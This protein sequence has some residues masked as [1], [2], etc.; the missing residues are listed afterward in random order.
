MHRDSR[1]IHRLLFVLESG[2]GQLPRF[3]SPWCSQAAATMLFVHPPLSFPHVLQG[4]NAPLDC[5]HVV[6][7]QAYVMCERLVHWLV[8]SYALGGEIGFRRVQIHFLIA[9]AELR[10]SE[11]HVLRNGVIYLFFFSFDDSNFL[12]TQRLLLMSRCEVTTLAHISSYFILST[13]LPDFSFHLLWINEKETSN[14]LVPPSLV[15]LMFP[16]PLK[17]WCTRF[18][19]GQSSWNIFQKP[20]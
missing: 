11:G 19:L 3:R 16:L 15:E 12:F 18:I 6:V 20:V 7:P 4:Y 14:N 1:R 10:V 9:D 17:S 13:N 5:I 2:R 8:S